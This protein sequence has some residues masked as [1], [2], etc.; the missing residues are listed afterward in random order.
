MEIDWS[1]FE[2]I[3]LEY[4]ADDEE[5]VVADWMIHGKEKTFL[6][7]EFEFCGINQGC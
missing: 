1:N 7:G 2:A 5:I 3:A 6:M 4:V